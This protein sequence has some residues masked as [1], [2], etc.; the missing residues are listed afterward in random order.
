MC[1]GQW[2]HKSLILP[3]CNPCCWQQG[4]SVLDVQTRHGRKAKRNR[5]A[6]D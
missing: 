6:G 3:H 1:A 5:I 4:I 2:Q